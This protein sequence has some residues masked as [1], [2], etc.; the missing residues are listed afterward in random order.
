MALFRAMCGYEI[1]G[2]ML[3]P[4]AAHQ[5]GRMPDCRVVWR[6]QIMLSKLRHWELT[7]RVRIQVPGTIWSA[8]GLRIDLP[9]QGHEGFDQGFRA[10]RTTGDV[11]IDGQKTVDT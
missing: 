1:L 11:H 7:R 6:H 10:R 5:L 2:F 9:L 4:L 8:Q 3:L